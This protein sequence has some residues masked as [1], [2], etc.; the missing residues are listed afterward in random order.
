[1][2]QREPLVPLNYPGHHTSPDQTNALAR[3]WRSS[4]SMSWQHV[5]AEMPARPKSADTVAKV[6][7]RTGPK[8]PRKL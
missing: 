7:N 5:V 3:R 2:R 4:Q 6:G 8:I 1:L